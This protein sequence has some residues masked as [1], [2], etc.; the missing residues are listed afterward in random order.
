MKKL[1]TLSALVC[2]TTWSAFSQSPNAPAIKGYNVETT[3]SGDLNK[4]GINDLV[5]VYQHKPVTY[6]DYENLE[7]LLVIYKKSNG[8]WV[9]WSESKTALLGTQEG[10]SK[11]DPL[12][13]VEIKNGILIIDH[14]GG[15]S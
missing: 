8:S 13:G 5:V 10:G 3:V 2:A 4:D 9:K 6:D 15:S 1:I 12:T 7:R 14:Y 11:G